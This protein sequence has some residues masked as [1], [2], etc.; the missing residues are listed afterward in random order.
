MN[1]PDHP[2][3]EDMQVLLLLGTKALASNLSLDVLLE[4]LKSSVEVAESRIQSFRDP[5][6]SNPRI[7]LVELGFQRREV[8]QIPA[9]KLFE[10]VAEISE[11]PPESFDRFGENDRIG[12]IVRCERRLSV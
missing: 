9:D 3:Y 11:G 7:N 1:E 2:S 8:L 10:A 5:K 4:S 12:G 6:F